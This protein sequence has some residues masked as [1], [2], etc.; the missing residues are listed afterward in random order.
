[1]N[2]ANRLRRDMANAVDVAIFLQYNVVQK[3]EENP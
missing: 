2:F 1:M 3:K